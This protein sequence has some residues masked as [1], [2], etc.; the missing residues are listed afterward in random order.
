MGTDDHALMKLPPIMEKLLQKGY[1]F[2]FF[3]AVYIL[4]RVYPDSAPPGEEGPLSQE[5]IRFRARAKLSFPATGVHRVE[6]RT[7]R[8]LQTIAERPETIQM[9]LSFLGLYGVNSPLPAYFSEVIVSAGE[10]DPDD[11]E[12]NAAGALRKFL[13]M[14]DHRTYSFFYR[15][16]K[17]YRYYLQFKPGA[18]DSVSQYVQ[19]FFGLG[20]PALRDLAGI[21]ADQLMPYAGILGQQTR[22]AASLR[23]MISDYFDGIA[24]KVKEFIPRWVNFPEEYRPQ[25]GTDHAGIKVRLDK[26]ATIGERVRDFNSKFQ[27]VLG[28][29]DTEM[30]L[31]FLPGRSYF[32]DIYHLVRFYV[33][34]KLLF[35]LELLL[36]REEAIPLQLG[37]ESEQ[38]G[39]NSWLDKPDENIVSVIFS[40]DEEPI[41]VGY[42][43]H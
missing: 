26:N 1:R 11:R 6:K 28:P 3:Q 43:E 22:C 8:D 14:I 33:S 4:E 19:S 42:I 36:R 34:D 39:W 25:L 37:S 18:Q 29:L 30:F 17:K 35:D 10:E 40:F 16:W 7:N 38:L 32:Q 31:K 9:I 15:S 13:D 20:T 27:I 21:G 2:N 23:K 5:T 24:V 41:G 12:E